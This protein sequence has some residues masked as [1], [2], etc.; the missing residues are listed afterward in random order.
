MEREGDRAS[1]RNEIDAEGKWDRSPRAGVG[2]EAGEGP[3]R[4]EWSASE[5]RGRWSSRLF[6]E[7]GDRR[8]RGRVGKDNK[9]GEKGGRRLGERERREGEKGGRREGE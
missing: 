3:V 7:E 2:V 5:R 9:E 4:R 6:A 1:P 8:E